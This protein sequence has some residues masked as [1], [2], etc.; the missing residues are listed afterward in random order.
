M[1]GVV[2]IMPGDTV[3]LIE[4]PERILVTCTAEVIPHPRLGQVIWINGPDVATRW[5]GA[6]VWYEPIEDEL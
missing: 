3:P 1:L 5:E 2:P 4:Q 6:R